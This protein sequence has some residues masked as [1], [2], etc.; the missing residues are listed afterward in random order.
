M[1]LGLR[2][3][4]SFRLLSI[5]I[6]AVAV[7]WLAAACDAKKCGRDGNMAATPEITDEY[8]H[9]VRLKYDDLF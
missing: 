7:L 5:L 9:E 6:C 2:G 4:S 8:I 3:Q 1:N